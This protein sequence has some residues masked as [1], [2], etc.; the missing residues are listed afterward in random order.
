M[1]AMSHPGSFRIALLSELSRAAILGYIAS[2]RSYII[3]KLPSRGT[4]STDTAADAVKRPVPIGTDMRT[5]LS[6]LR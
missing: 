6:R 1:L 2:P 3:G 5:Y 4:P